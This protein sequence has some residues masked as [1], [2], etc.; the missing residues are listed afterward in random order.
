LAVTSAKRSAAAP[1]LPTVAEAGVPGFVA[2]TWYGLATTA[3]TPRAV[4]DRL[5][6]EVRKTLAD[7]EVRAQLA[8]QGIEEPAPGT[9]EQLGELI[10]A[11]LVKWEK[12]VRE[13]GATIN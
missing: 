13:S 6:A 10:R 9:P 3:G 7:P 5:N 4:I 8:A 1:D 2:T 11:E 12:V